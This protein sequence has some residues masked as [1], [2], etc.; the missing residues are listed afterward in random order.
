MAN[1]SFTPIP[2]WILKEQ[3]LSSAELYI[4]SYMYKGWTYAKLE[5]YEYQISYKKLAEGL[6]YKTTGTVIR[7]VKKME[8]LGILTVERS[9]RADNHDNKNVFR[10]NEDKVYVGQGGNL[11]TLLN[12]DTEIEGLKNEDLRVSSLRHHTK[13]IKELKKYKLKEPIGTSTGDNEVD[14]DHMPELFDFSEVD[15]NDKVQCREAVRQ[16]RKMMENR[17]DWILRHESDRKTMFSWWIDTFNEAASVTVPGMK[18]FYGC[19]ITEYQQKLMDGVDK[20]YLSEEY[21]KVFRKTA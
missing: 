2:D 10:F 6:N 12:D 17:L 14:S 9:K 5:G 8:N 18:D 16:S 15:M 19:L 21:F 7:T 3:C 20:D 4:F 1:I 13:E 11:E